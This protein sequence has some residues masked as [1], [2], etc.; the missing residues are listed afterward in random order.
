[1]KNRFNLKSNQT[2]KQKN[3]SIESKLQCTHFLFRAQIL[4]KTKITMTDFN[5]RKHTSK[6]TELT[7]FYVRDRK[8]S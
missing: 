4:T 3:E 5:R 2:N 8:Y 6:R 7:K 1:M